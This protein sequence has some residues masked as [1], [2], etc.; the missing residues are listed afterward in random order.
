MLKLFELFLSTKKTCCSAKRLFC[1]LV[2][3]YYFKT[4]STNLL[5]LLIFFC[6]MKYNNAGLN[7][8][9]SA[10]MTAIYRYSK[11]RQLIKDIY[12]SNNNEFNHM[13]PFKTKCLFYK[14]RQNI[15]KLR[16][17]NLKCVYC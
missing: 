16:Y 2:F 13:A 15:W 11:D 8:N 9:S 17:F 4:F 3:Y 6:A 1:Q 14:A 10:P 12:F 7:V 5:V